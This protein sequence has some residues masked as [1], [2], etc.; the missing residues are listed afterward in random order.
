M[1]TNFLNK[2]FIALTVLTLML[3]GCGG[4]GGAGTTSV[5]NSGDT[6]VQ[7]APTETVPAAVTIIS[8]KA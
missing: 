6:P 7:E 5:P 1:Y 4:G 8:G 2:R 3:A